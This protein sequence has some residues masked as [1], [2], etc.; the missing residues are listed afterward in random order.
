MGFNV[1]GFHLDPIPVG[2]GIEEKLKG[3]FRN[4]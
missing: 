3:L 2:S 4:P 1:I